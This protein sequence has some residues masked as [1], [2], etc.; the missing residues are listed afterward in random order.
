[1]DDE[2][3]TCAGCAG[4]VAV[5]EAIWLPVGDKAKARPY[6]CSLCCNTNGESARITALETA[7][8]AMTKERDDQ[9]E[10][11]RVLGMCVEARRREKIARDGF[12][13]HD[14]TKQ[15]HAHHDWVKAIEDRFTADGLVD[16][17]PIARAA[18]EGER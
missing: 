3:Y 4:Q 1:M 9:A 11:V 7:L 6:C 2:T 14:A 13:V 5:V 17:N 8:A 12:N 18:V 10:A 16:T 15:T